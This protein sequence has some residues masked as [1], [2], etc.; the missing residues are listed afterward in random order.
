M[1]IGEIF[2]LT[3]FLCYENSHVKNSNMDLK[4][5]G[6]IEIWEYFL[7]KISHSP[8]DG[9]MYCSPNNLPHGHLPTGCA[10]VISRVI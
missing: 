5:I 6:K 8:I 3:K 1:L 2:N 10:Q 9:M 4:K 7:E